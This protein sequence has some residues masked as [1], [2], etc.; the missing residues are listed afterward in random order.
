MQVLHNRFE[1]ATQAEIARVR[2]EFSFAIDFGDHNVA[3]DDDA[4]TS[5]AP[6]DAGTWVQGWLWIGDDPTDRSV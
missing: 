6:E 1:G 3:V 4:L 5:R 2:E